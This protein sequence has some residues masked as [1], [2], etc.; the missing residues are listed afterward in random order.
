VPWQ[1]HHLVRAFRQAKASGSVKPKVEFGGM[2]G[3][4]PVL[5]WTNRV[6]GER[7][8][9]P[10]EVE[11]AG[12]YAVRLTAGA[13]PGFGACD[14]ELDGKVVLKRADFRAPEDDELD[15][16]LG[17]HELAKGTHR[18]AFHAIATEGRHAGPIAVEM[19]RLLPLPPEATRAVKTHNEAHF[20][21]LG[22]GRAIYAYRLAYGKVPDSLEAVVK[23]GLMSRRYLS[24]ENEKP[25][26][27]WREGDALAV[28][29]NGPEPWT[30]RWEGLDARR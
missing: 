18:L 7:L 21:R 19:L 28:E 27:C 30:H 8:T 24:D 22:I 2:F 26:R 11:P 5:G 16:E 6:A 20:I 12:R 10:F 3:A 9:V 25:L 17:T 13:A 14:I 4:R 29:S 1:Y 23:A 15:L